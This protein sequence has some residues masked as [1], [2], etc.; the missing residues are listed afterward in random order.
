[1]GSERADVENE[2][3]NAHAHLHAE[4]QN[5][6]SMYDI[7]AQL[8]NALLVHVPLPIHS[9]DICKCAIPYPMVR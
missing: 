3:I 5:V 8:L 1:M 4:L 6:R 2:V 9:K 7:L